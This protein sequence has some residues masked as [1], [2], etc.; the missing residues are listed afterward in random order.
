MNVEILQQEIKHLTEVTY[1]FS[2]VL[3]IL[4]KK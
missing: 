1:Y 3:N 4:N 2:K